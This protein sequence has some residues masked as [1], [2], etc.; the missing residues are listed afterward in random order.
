MDFKI[1]NAWQELINGNYILI[2]AGS[3]ARDPDQ[4]V[5]LVESDSPGGSGGYLTPGK[6]GAV[7]IVEVKGYR[8]VLET[9]TKVIFYFDV[10]ARSFV[11]SLDEVVST[12]TPRPIHTTTP[13]QVLA[14]SASPYP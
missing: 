3:L 11:N 8:L 4:G 12:A 1:N 5:I 14:P 2:F 7:R 10:P 6:N 13:T 9:Q